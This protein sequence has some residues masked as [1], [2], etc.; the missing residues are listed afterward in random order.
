MK[1][2]T[3]KHSAVIAGLAGALSLAAV[4]SSSAAWH[5]H[6]WGP[7]TAITTMRRV[8]WSLTQVRPITT[9][10]AARCGVLAIAVSLSAAA[11]RKK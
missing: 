6:G 5:G 1:I 4:T 11:N 8:P 3:L 2:G 10:M 9:T 7:G